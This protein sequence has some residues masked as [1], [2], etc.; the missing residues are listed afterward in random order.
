MRLSVPQ[1]EETIFFEKQTKYCL[2]IPLFNEGE[3]YFRQV[4]KMRKNGL[5]GKI[6]VVICDAGSKDGTTDPVFLKKSGH[7]ALLVRSGKGR[8]STDIRMG[9][10]WALQQG[11]EGFITVDGNDKDGTEAVGMFIDALDRGYDYVQGSRFVKGGRGIH[12]PFVRQAAMKLINEP[13]MTFCARRHLTDT[14]NGFRAY[15][16]RFLTDR[17]VLPFRDIFWGYELIYYLPI[18]ACCLGFKT[19]EIP[20]TRVY[21]KGKIPSKV[22]GLR[23]NLYQMS[24]LYHCL[25]KHYDPESKYRFKEHGRCI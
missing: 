19:C 10:Y 12:T 4:K 3:R 23:G 2:L 18:K 22:G 16:K 9:Y 15:S 11:Y 20:V 21:P 6:D 14:T 13:V 25:W 17:R 24:I 7:R 1:F 5:F 8:Y